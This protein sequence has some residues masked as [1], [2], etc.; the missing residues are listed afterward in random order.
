MNLSQCRDSD[1][2]LLSFD[3]PPIQACVSNLSAMILLFLDLQRAL[4]YSP[5]K[6]EDYSEFHSSPEAFR[7][8]CLP[9]IGSQTWVRSGWEFFFASG[10]SNPRPWRWIKSARDQRVKCNERRTRPCHRAYYMR[11]STPFHSCVEVQSLKLVSRED[12]TGPHPL[13]TALPRD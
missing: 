3:Y 1:V 11:G 13:P 8:I 10:E 7:Y 12:R 4:F 6:V 2:Y 5:S 9:T